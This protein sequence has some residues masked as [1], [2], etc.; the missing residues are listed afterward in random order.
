MLQWVKRFMP[1]SSKPEVP[2]ERW[3]EFRRA[4]RAALE[5][6][7][8]PMDDVVGHAI[9]PF[10]AGGSVD[11]FFFPARRPGTVVVTMDL[12]DPD[13]NG[14]QSQALGPYELVACTR[15]RRASPYAID[16]ETGQ[17]AADVDDER[18]A[19]I[20]GWFCRLL[21]AIARDALKMEIQPGDAYEF[22]AQEDEPAHYVI[23]DRFDSSGQLFEVEGK[24]FGLLL[25]VEVFASE[26]EYAQQNGMDA[27]IAKLKEAEAYPYSDLDRQPVA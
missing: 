10:E 7:L 6:I 11:L 1:R 19:A 5:R 27:L 8:G 22:P 2:P 21:T 20:T 13:G 14:P 17:V 9:I 15:V 16:R 24:E 4:K 25:C 12:I 23:F 26:L 18:F 3:S